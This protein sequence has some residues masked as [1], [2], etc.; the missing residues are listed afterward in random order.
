[1]LTH[2]L[3]C[4][5]ATAHKL[6]RAF[7]FHKDDVAH[8]STVPDLYVSAT[9]LLLPEILP[10]SR[11]QP[12]SHPA[13]PVDMVVAKPYP[14]PHWKTDMSVCGSNGR[15]RI[16]IFILLFFVKNSIFMLMRSIKPLVSSLAEGGGGGGGG[17]M[18][19]S[20]PCHA[21]E[22]EMIVCNTSNSSNSMAKF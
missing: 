22:S 2:V 10:L 19:L 1:M 21:R 13:F 15:S 17:R 4:I 3:A 9:I 6:T 16:C 11:L 5:Y 12:N 14:P 7:L 20:A 8:I 18:V